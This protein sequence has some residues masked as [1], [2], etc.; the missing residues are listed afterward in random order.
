MLWVN[1][2]D[3]MVDIE[4][5]QLDGVDGSSITFMSESGALEFFLTASSTPQFSNFNGS[6][7]NRVKK[8]N[9]DLAT[10][11]GFAPL[12][13]IQTLGFHFCKWAPSSADILIDRSRSFTE[14]GYPLDVLWADIQWAKSPPE[15]VGGDETPSD[16]NYMYFVFNEQNFTAPKLEELHSEL[17]DNG[18]RITVIVDPHIKVSSSYFVYSEGMQMQRQSS[19]SSVHNIFV[20]AN[21]KSSDPF[22]GKCWPGVSTWIDFLNENAQEFWSNLFQPD[23]FVGSNYLYSAWNDMNEPSVFES[24]TKTLPLETVHVKADGRQFEHRDIHNAYGGLQ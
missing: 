17:E 16:D 7:T 6:T 4:T 11:T 20:R 15:I 5:M 23:R 3:T 19:E 13:M 9:R 10:I 24:P 22:E 14:H 1:S 8:L 2:A 12:P 21:A 18:R